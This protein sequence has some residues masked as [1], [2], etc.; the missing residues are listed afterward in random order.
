MP[1]SSCHQ[2]STMFSSSHTS[3]LHYRVS[4]IQ[5]P[6]PYASNIWVLDPS[7]LTLLLEAC[8]EIEST[9]TIITL[10]CINY[11]HTYM[12][13]TNSLNIGRNSTISDSTTHLNSIPIVEKS[14]Q[15]SFRHRFNNFCQTNKIPHFWLDFS[16]STIETSLPFEL[17]LLGVLLYNHHS[18]S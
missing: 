7:Y 18:L 11:M 10:K 1:P 2:L 6:N 15:F 17:K 12:A 3:S 13:K 4:N 5:Q 16:Q 8:K 14:E 9:N